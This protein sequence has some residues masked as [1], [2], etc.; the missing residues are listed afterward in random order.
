MNLQSA[1]TS[2]IRGYAI[3]IQARG[4]IENE[5]AAIARLQTMRVFDVPTIA[6][7]YYRTLLE[8]SR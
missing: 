6:R 8:G 4:W 7:F 5:Q 3:Q 1:V 2:D